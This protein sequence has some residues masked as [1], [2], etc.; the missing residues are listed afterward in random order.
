MKAGEPNFGSPVCVD[1]KP[2][3]DAASAW[4]RSSIRSLTVSNPTERRT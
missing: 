3:Q 1:S 2:D 4:S